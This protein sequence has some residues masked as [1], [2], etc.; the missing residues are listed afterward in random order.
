MKRL[1]IIAILLCNAV[2]AQNLP[3]SIDIR[4]TKFM[5]L[6]SFS[7]V[8]MDSALAN[9]DLRTYE[10]TDCE[11]ILDFEKMECRVYFKG[12]LHGRAPIIA[13]KQQTPEY[14]TE[15]DHWE[16]VVKLQESADDTE[17]RLDIE[18]N[19]FLYTF[20]YDSEDGFYN[21]VLQLAIDEKIDINN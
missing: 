2:I 15:F 11:Y 4:F 12:N 3:K 6:Q 13:V 17:I 10:D 9:P 7:K 8:P 18:N 5:E 19:I 20:V 21:R 16:Y 14:K 1:L